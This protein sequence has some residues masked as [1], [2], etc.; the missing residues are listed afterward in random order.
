MDKNK[1]RPIMSVL[2]MLAGFM[3]GFYIIRGVRKTAPIVDGGSKFDEVMWYIGND[4]VE[5]PDAHQLQD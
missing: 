1:I 3:V 4:Y 2:L 5:Q